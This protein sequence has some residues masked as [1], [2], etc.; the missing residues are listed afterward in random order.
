[1][2]RNRILYRVPAKHLKNDLREEEQPTI[3]SSH[4]RQT[5]TDKKVVLRRGL[6]A[7]NDF[8]TA[9]ANCKPLKLRIE[10]IS[11]HKLISEVNY[12]ST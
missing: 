8:T 6:R 5:M 10:L 7:L 3:M 2:P 12:G 9:I 4:C 11:L 1:M